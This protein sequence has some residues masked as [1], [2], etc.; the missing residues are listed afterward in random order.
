MHRMLGTKVVADRVNQYQFEP[1]PV[2]FTIRKM[3][4]QLRITLV[5]LSRVFEMQ[6]FETTGWDVEI[7]SDGFVPMHR[8]ELKGVRV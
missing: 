6:L 4:D 2:E 7:V 3:R 8:R 1:L 5:K